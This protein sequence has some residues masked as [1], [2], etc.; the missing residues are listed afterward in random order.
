MNFGRLFP[1]RTLLAPPVRIITTL[2]SS[3]LHSHVTLNLEW[4][5]KFKLSNPLLPRKWHHQKPNYYQLREHSW[6][7]NLLHMRNVIQRRAE[8]VFFIHNL[9]V[10]IHFG[11]VVMRWTDLA[12]CQ[13]E[14]PFPGSL[15][16]TFLCFCGWTTVRSNPGIYTFGLFTKSVSSAMWPP[17]LTIR[18]I[19]DTY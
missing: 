1:C 6:P 7:C 13:L 12:P 9:L 2:L 10:R 5:D 18:P 14:F 17:T 19:I 3:L 16:S 4:F 11:I 15:T 8:R